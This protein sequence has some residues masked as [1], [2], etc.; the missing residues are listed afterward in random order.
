MADRSYD[1]WTKGQRI[2]TNTRVLAAS[3]NDA[4]ATYAF[5]KGLKT[6]DCDAVHIPM[7][8]RGLAKRR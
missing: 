1:V 3:K 2:T 5:P 4:L 7:W 8:K 6:I